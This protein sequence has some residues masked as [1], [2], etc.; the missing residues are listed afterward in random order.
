ME[1]LWH[2]NSPL[3]LRI[4]SVAGEYVEEQ[5]PTFQLEASIDT[6]GEVITKTVLIEYS[7]AEKRI[8][9]IS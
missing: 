4:F 3:L 1:E 7:P 2:E 9:V 5:R 8:W 6:E